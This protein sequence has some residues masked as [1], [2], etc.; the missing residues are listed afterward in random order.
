MIG[1]AAENNHAELFELLEQARVEKWT[2]LD[3]SGRSLA[4]LPGEVWELES[5]VR[6]DVSGNLLETLPPAIAKLTQG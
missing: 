3:L 2:E 5:L 6:L 1:Q 4:V